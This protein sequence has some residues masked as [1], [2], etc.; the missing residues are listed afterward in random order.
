MLLEL[1]WASNEY[2]ILKLYDMNIDC[3]V[4][5]CW[6]MIAHIVL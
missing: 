3:D 6:I 5:F 1:I 2:D 4:T